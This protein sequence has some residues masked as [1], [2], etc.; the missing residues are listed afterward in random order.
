VVG[1]VVFNG[2]GGSYNIIPT[3]LK[4]LPGSGSKKSSRILA[5]YWI[6]FMVELQPASG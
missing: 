1:D 2:A 3:I 6:L 4:I 5:V